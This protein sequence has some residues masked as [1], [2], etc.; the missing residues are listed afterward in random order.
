MDTFT[1]FVV[2]PELS[3]LGNNHPIKSIHSIHNK[4]LNGNSFPKKD[5]HVSTDHV[6]LVAI[7]KV[8]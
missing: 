6:D 8:V 5:C 3:E 1:M 2:T 4:F 7:L